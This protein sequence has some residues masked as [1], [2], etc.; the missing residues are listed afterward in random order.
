MNLSGILYFGGSVKALTFVLIS[1][2]SSSTFAAETDQFYAKD[3]VIRDSSAEINGFFHEKIKVALD[4]INQEKKAVSCRLVA[5]EVLVQVVGEV[6]L[7]EYIKNKAVSKVT[8]FVKK[9]PLVERFPDDSMSDDEYRETSIYKNRALP[10]SKAAIARTINVNGVYLGTDKISHFS[11]VGRIYYKNF[12]KALD[13]GLRLE[14]AE[15]Y[16]VAKGMKQEIA[17]LGYVLGGTLSYGDLEANYQGLVFGRDMCEGDK[18][19]LVKSQGQWIHNPENNFDIKKYIN[20]KFDEA[21]NVSFWAPRMWKKM[22]GDISKSYCENK[23][24]PNYLARKEAYEKI[25]TSSGSDKALVGFLKENPK[26]A[27]EN[28]LLNK[29]IKCEN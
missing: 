28:Q 8:S 21:F 7:K 5:K 22:S 13:R 1:A 23:L 27:R 9:S 19:L 15:K 24:N 25:L 14:D 4:K 6:S 26:Y 10:G 17:I 16:A 20:P 3:A 11:M 2:I 29:E 12:L 18:P